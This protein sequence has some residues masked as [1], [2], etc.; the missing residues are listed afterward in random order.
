MFDNYVTGSRHCPLRNSCNE[1]AYKLS[2]TKLQRVAYLGR[3]LRLMKDLLF[4]QMFSIF[5]QIQ[6]LVSRSSLPAVLNVR[7]LL[8]QG[9]VPEFNTSILRGFGS[10]PN[11]NP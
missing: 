10:D 1:T 3:N 4:R 8:T 11:S 2:G 7:R 5:F 9:D 6:R